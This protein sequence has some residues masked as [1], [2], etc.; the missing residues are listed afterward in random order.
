MALRADRLIGV[1]G[2][3]GR[4]TAGGVL[5]VVRGA[6]GAAAGAEHPEQSSSQGEGDSQP[7][8]DIDVFAHATVHT[9]V[10]QVLVESTSDGGE[11]G[12]SS[13]GGCGSEKESNTRDKRGDAATPATADGEDTDD[14]FDNG[15]DKC[16]DIGDEHPLGDILVEVQR[17][18][19]ATRKAILHAGLLQIPD[20]DR[21]EPELSLGLRALR[22]FEFVVGD[23]PITVTPQTNVVEVLEVKLLLD[24]LQGRGDIS[25]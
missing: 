20:L 24:L 5:V 9:I 25:I 11:H 4:D 1:R 15:G 23:V 17:L 21:V 18:A 2:L 6:T 10:L 8:G 16:D 12:G 22:D 19:Q 3:L 7:G 14:Q 13:H